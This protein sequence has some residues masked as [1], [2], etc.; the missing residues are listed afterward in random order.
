LTEFKHESGQ[1]VRI[2]A[3]MIDSGVH[4]DSVYR[5]VKG[6]QARRIWV[7]KG[8]SES[9]KEILAKFSLNNQYRVKL[10]TV[11]TDTAKDR[12]FARMKIP[13]PGP[14][15]MH[16]PDWIE[17]EYLEQLT[18]EKAVRKYK[19]GKGAVREY[20]KTRARNEALDLEVYAPAAL[21]SLG[22]RKIRCLGELADT[23]RGHKQNRRQSEEQLAGDQVA[24]SRGLSGGF[25]RESSGSSW[26]NRWRE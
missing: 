21:Y 14:G 3:T 18:S 2:S 19:K 6:R 22:Q 9:G 11:G 8:N 26:L 15:F 13:A 4:T 16:L 23:L 5:F 7:L 24:P 1:L 25:R 10:W 20:I 17:D 12:I